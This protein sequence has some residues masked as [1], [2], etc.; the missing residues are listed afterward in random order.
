MLLA[1]SAMAADDCGGKDCANPVALG[2]GAEE[3][4]VTARKREESLQDIPG[5]LTAFSVENLQRVGAVNN[6]DVALLTVNF[7]TVQQI[8]RR[9]DRPTVRG[10]SSAA[11]GGE[12]NAG[13]FIDGVFVSG[14]IATATLGPV[15]RVEILRGPQSALFGRATFAGAIN[16]VTRRPSN[17]FSGQVQ[18][19]VGSNEIRVVNA[20]ASGPLIRD[21]LLFFTGVGWDRFGGEWRNSLQDGQAPALNFIDPPQMGDNSRLGGTDSRDI[22]GKLLWT[23]T[24]T[25]TV[26]LKLGYTKSADDHYAQLIVEPGELNCFLPT[27]DRS[28][29]PW[30][31]TSQG[32]F[33]GTIDGAHVT[34]AANNPFNPGSPAFDPAT[35]LPNSDNLV[36]N[37]PRNGG[38]RQSRINL[39]DF[40]N[41]MQLPDFS[42][43][44][45]G[46]EPEDWIA[47]PERPG[48]RR[49]QKRALLQLDQDIGAWTATARIALNDD[50]LEQAYDLDRTEQRYFGGTFTMFERAEVEDQ[51]FEARISS[52]LDA[53]LRGS[54][55][56]Y[57][58]RSEWESR[59]K[60]FVGQ[61]F[62]RLSD[63]TF[64][65][66]E[67]LAVFGSLEYSLNDAWTLSAEA[68]FAS[69]K[70]KID[71][72]LTCDRPET[73]ETE[74]LPVDDE[75]DTD[76][77][78]PRFTVRYQPNDS[79]TL[80][81][82]VAKGNKPAE[83]NTAYFRQATADACE[84]IVAIEEGATRIEEEKAWTYEV[85]SKNVWLDGR[86]TANLALFYIDWDNQSV[87]QT[88]EVGNTLTQITRNAGQSEVS[89]LELET[90]FVL[91]DNLIANFSYGLA[92]GKFVNYA[93]PAFANTT[94][95]GLDVNGLLDNDSNNVK[96]N[97]LPSSPKHS[98]VMGMDY[99]GDLPLALF[100]DSAA[101]EWFAGSTFVL[102]TDR[103]TAADNF[104]KLPNRKLW[105]GRIGLDAD[106]WRLTAFVNNI[107]DQR[108]PVS[109][110]S[111]PSLQ[112]LNWQNGVDA[113]GMANGAAGTS[114]Q[115]Y[116][117]FPTPGRNYGIDL[118]V[119]FGD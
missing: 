72:P 99:T 64:R 37:L 46:T 93:D 107:L 112:G 92:D 79:T 101:V 36:N 52:P 113:M 13:Y 3:L 25:T 68:R 20:W 104:I 96:G 41:G 77:F 100:S 98:F 7:N 53:Q 117:V 10:Q 84:S 16:Y 24:D 86:L 80:Y 69:D 51:S 32:A 110:F 59:Q 76:A 60:Q 56:M 118:I 81:A 114:V 9:L 44:F 47:T 75:I 105:N 106:N 19:K 62:G 33:C 14:S 38:L 111:F 115:G 109:V 102:E 26:T 30:F 63:P 39:P 57:Y 70:K 90:A 22:V 31:A 2:F 4:V 12:P 18:S 67:N 1:S 74:A 61:G 55:G 29:E 88:I 66:I 45:T 40:R 27:A 103:Y 83:F 87:F 116:S 35:Y 94:G 21:K 43:F 6:E 97:R 78:T 71:S 23:P 95:I 65:E 85:G 82:L 54:L 89:G 11:T 28:D 91:T 15:E 17:E 119:S 5:S 49:E 58:F 42:G 8:G 50:V 73:P 108:A 48:T 34:Y